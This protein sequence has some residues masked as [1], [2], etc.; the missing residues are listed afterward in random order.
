MALCVVVTFVSSTLIP[1]ETELA[2]SFSVFEPIESHF[3]CSHALND[4]GVVGKTF[5]SGV[6]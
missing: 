3:N 4:N 2:L 5:G 1:V 6:I